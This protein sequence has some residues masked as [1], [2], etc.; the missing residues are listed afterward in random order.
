MGRQ[1]K[2]I[3]PL[4][5][6]NQVHNFSL[7]YGNPNS[8][9]SPMKHILLV[10]ILLSSTAL[11]LDKLPASLFFV[12]NEGQWE[13]PFAFKANVGN[14]LYYVTPQGMTLDIREYKKPRNQE[15]KK[16]IEFDPRNSRDDDASVRGHVL[17]INYLN[18]NIQPEIIG[19]NKLASYSNYFLGRDSCKWRSFV[20]HYQTVRMK[21]V[22]L[23]IDVVQ[24]IQAEGVETLYRVQAGA[25]TQQISI[26][27][28]GLT[29]PLRTD[30]QD[31]LILSTSLGEIKEKAPYAYQI[32]NHR[33]VEVPVRFQVLANNQYGLSF[34]T[35]D[36]AHELVI[37]PLVYST[38]LGGG[39]WNETY[40]IA[41][42]S[43]N[44]YI[45]CGT[46]DAHN[47][48]ITPGAYQMENPWQFQQQ[49]TISKFTLSGSSLVFSTYL[50]GRSHY[51]Q[52]A[53]CVLADR[54]NCI[55]VLGELGQGIINFPLTRDAF[56][57]TAAGES[58][59][60][61]ARL[62][63][64]GASLEFCSFWGGSGRDSGGD[65][66]ID[67]TGMVYVSGVTTSPDFPTTS[68]ALFPQFEGI[69]SPFISIFDPRNS[70]I[71]YS[72]LFSGS[73]NVG[74]TLLVS[75]YHVWLY[76]WSASGGI[77]VTTDALQSNFLGGGGVN[78]FLSLLDLSVGQVLYSSYFGGRGSTN[79]QDLA[80]ISQ[81]EIAMAGYASSPD[82]PVT[83]NAFDTT[84][85]RQYVGFISRLTLPNIIVSSTFYGGNGEPP[86][87]TEILNVS[88]NSDSSIV[89]QGAT[90]E[91]TPITPNAYDSLFEHGIFLCRFSSDLSRLEYGSF[92]GGS[93]SQDVNDM[94]LSEDNSLWLAGSTYSLDFPTTE[95]AFQRQSPSGGV[96][97]GFITHFV[98][99]PATI[100]PPRSILPYNCSLR[101]YPNPFNSSINI[102]F[103]LPSSSPAQVVVY[104]LLGRTAYAQ[105]LGR[106][107]AGEHHTL[108]DMPGLPSGTY[109]VRMQ[110]GKE[111]TEKKIV[112][113]K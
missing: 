100:N 109:I 49:A 90:G 84:F 111:Q 81:N 51:E 86:S 9:F 39:G 76:G 43:V 60:F 33:Q 41:F 96:N 72:T 53:R 4:A 47:F 79:I 102:A 54:N 48:P 88:V 110:A 29:A 65:L 36:T 40:G 26:Q 1:I 93:T 34:E 13:E 2:K 45:V 57:T 91:R 61:L 55:Y 21:D 37:D 30:G 20:G 17:K 74:H 83:P 73:Y 3:K 11:A 82:F 58:E 103:T 38:F 42:D 104:D 18:A 78:A 101:A 6:S 66:Q 32:I 69:Y 22:W 94:I 98:L 15:A 105:D 52:G 85:H 108:L 92:F 23:G 89:V 46:T 35:F 97:D 87:H 24:K 5:V 27:I 107:S 44:N 106:M 50:G 28:E 56:D 63:E 14:V 71:I 112:L 113:L 80:M 75:P 95:N 77:P 7:H 70:T 19:E 10:L 68:N 25:N 12:A 59:S 62:S 8:G 67:S 64:D 99:D 31:N 16:P